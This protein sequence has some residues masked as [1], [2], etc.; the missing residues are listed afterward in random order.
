MSNFL[1]GSAMVLAGVFIGLRKGAFGRCII[2]KKP[3]DKILVLDE[4][5]CFWNVVYIQS[6]QQIIFCT[7]YT[8]L[9][10]FTFIDERWD[11]D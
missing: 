5:G 9:R 11:S 3:R 2:L 4:G 1:I 10:P 8:S 7:R 6:E